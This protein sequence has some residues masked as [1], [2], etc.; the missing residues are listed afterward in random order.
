MRAML[1]LVIALVFQPPVLL[2]QDSRALQVPAEF[3]AFFD[4]YSALMKKYPEAAKR[5][6]MFDRNPTSTPIIRATICG[7]NWC[8]SESVD[9]GAG[10]PRCTKCTFCPK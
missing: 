2:A 10:T 9:E 1:C 4:D 6:G 8:C 5:F 3:K 7:V